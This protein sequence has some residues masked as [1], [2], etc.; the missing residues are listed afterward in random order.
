MTRP[1]Y[2]L[3]LQPS[4]KGAAERAAAAD[5]TSLNQ[6]IN[7]AVAEKLAALDTETYFHERAARGHRG[8]FIAFLD[9]AGD[10]PPASGDDVK[11]PRT[12]KRTRR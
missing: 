2:S 5:G 12:R 7:V 6:F 4:L 8:A 3:R 9:G 10:A 1:N 11:A